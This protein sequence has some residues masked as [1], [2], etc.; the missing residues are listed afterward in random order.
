MAPL[1]ERPSAH[2]SGAQE[3]R[4]QPRLGQDRARRLPLGQPRRP[5]HTAPRRAGREPGESRSGE[6]GMLIPRLGVRLRAERP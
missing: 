3:G 1:P 2:L 6:Q 5:A 4:R